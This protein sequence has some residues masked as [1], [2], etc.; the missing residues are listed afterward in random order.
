[1]A[2][3]VIL[4]NMFILFILS[5]VPRIS[6]SISASD[7]CDVEGYTIISCTWTERRS[8]DSKEPED[9]IILEN[10]MIFRISGY[11]GRLSSSRVVVF[12]RKLELQGA[13][14]IVYKIFIDDR[15]R[16]FSA[17]RIR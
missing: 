2:K 5:F 16:I 8:F 13:E 11:Y 17:Y 7:L 10:G 6:D 12:A 4:L 3:K 1:M 15:D 9:L 14:K